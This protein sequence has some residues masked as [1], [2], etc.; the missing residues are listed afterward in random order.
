MGDL[1]KFPNRRGADRVP[2]TKARFARLKG[3]STRWV[4]MQVAAGM[5]A[6][7]NRKGRRVFYLAETEPWLEENGSR[8]TDTRNVD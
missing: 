6:H 8:P 2:L 3:R 1:L 5:P 4:E 7:Y